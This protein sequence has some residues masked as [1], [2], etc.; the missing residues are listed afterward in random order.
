MR[1]LQQAAMMT[2]APTASC[3]GGLLPGRDAP[4]GEVEEARAVVHAV[5]REGAWRA[6]NVFGTYEHQRASEGVEWRVEGSSVCLQGRRGVGHTV[7]APSDGGG[8]AR[9]GSPRLGRT[10]PSQ[11]FPRARGEQ[12]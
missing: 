11:A 8:M 12:Q 9:L 4:I 3:F 1:P 5:G 6:G 7:A 10:S 2:A